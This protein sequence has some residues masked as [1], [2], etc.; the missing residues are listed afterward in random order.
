MRISTV[1]VAS[2]AL[3]LFQ[4]AAQVAV[5]GTFPPHLAGSFAVESSNISPLPESIKRLAPPS[6][7][8]PRMNNADLIELEEEETRAKQLLSTSSN[9]RY[10][11]KGAYQFGKALE[12]QS[13]A[14]EGFQ[15]TLHSGHWMPFS[16]YMR[17]SAAL[18]ERGYKVFS[19]KTRQLHNQ[20]LQR[21]RNMYGRLPLHLVAQQEEAEDETMVWQLEVVSEGALSLNLIFSAFELPEGAE[22]YVTGRH[23]VL[24]AFTGSVNNKPDGKFATAPVKGDRL[25]LQVFLPRHLYDR[26]VLP[27]LELSHVVHG[28]RPMFT[29]STRTALD[30]PAQMRQYR[31]EEAEHDIVGREHR[32]R[33]RPALL[34]QSANSQN[35][36]ATDSESAHVMS[37]KCNLDV[38]C[39]HEYRDQSRS[40]GVI[41]TDYNQKYC[42]GSLVNNARQDGRQLFLTAYHC[43]GFSDTSEHLVMFNYEK[44]QCGATGEEINEHDTAQG[45][46]KLGAYME[47]DYTL[48]EIVE[49]IPDGYDLYMSG[50]SASPLAPSTRIKN[51]PPK[52]EDE[53]KPAHF[54]KRGLYEDLR[55]EV[56]DYLSRASEAIEEEAEEALRALQLDKNSKRPRRGDRPGGNVPN[57][58]PNPAEVEPIFGIHH[59]GGDIMKVSF[60]LNGTLPKACWTDCDPDQY[61]HW[62]IPR[63]DR[64]TTEPGSSGSPLFNADKRIVGQLHGGTASCYNS[65]GYDVYGGLHASF[66]APPRVKDRLST[67]LD[68][69][70]TGVQF[71]DGYSLAAARSEYRLRMLDQDAH[72]PGSWA[73]KHQQHGVQGDRDEYGNYV[74]RES[75]AG[76]SGLHGEDLTKPLKEDRQMWD[77]FFG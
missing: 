53:D 77:R 55:Q 67:Y 5:Q 49:P 52:V 58:A 1:L 42:T 70:H 65:K 4:A 13:F 39:F 10:A 20:K 47:S 3:A 32:Q 66:R 37:G 34:D 26:G 69:D 75:L 51:S 33:R 64:G 63:W 29:A 15:S 71:M 12:L 72:H 2:A 46:V 6:L 41:L 25:L 18:E 38:A 19:A 61:F 35:P 68:P 36:F 28:Y 48:Y 30:A 27:R 76:P 43:T 74:I 45:L 14:P 50:W 60:V 59:P 54:M 7:A 57:P 56:D 40:V 62:Q 11:Y 73:K 24:G 17:A 23:H 22:F 44:T 21:Q 8:L 16:R 9:E 31:G